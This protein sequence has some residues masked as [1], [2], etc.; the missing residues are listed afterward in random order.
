MSRAYIDTDGINT[1][2]EKMLEKEPAARPKFN[3]LPVLR[4][5]DSRSCKCFVE[6]P[7]VLGSLRFGTGDLFPII[8]DTNAVQFSY[9]AW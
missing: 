7:P 3:D 4:K 9:L 1:F 2:L 5:F 8:A 6:C